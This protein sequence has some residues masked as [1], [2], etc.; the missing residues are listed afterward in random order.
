MRKTVT[1]CGK[2]LAL[3]NNALLPRQYRKEFGRDMMVD[4]RKMAE[5]YQKDPDNVNMEVLENVT[6]LMLR[7]AGNDVG[8]SVEEWL[9]SLDD[10]LSVYLAMPDVVA[11]WIKGLK[12]TA[13]PKKK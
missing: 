7:A 10:S 5:G 4:M 11:L 1:I 13:K 12:T 3:E 9:A 6:W 8:D 2:T